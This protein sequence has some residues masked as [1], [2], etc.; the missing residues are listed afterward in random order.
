MYLYIYI[1]IVFVGAY[2]EENRH[3]TKCDILSLNFKWSIGKTSIESTSSTT[4][5]QVV[6]Q[7]DLPVDIVRR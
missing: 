1:N 5:I 3:Y 7:S 4:V 2:D 6:D